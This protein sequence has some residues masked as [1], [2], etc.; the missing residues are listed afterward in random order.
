MIETLYF[1]SLILVL[2]L[3]KPHPTS[4]IF[5][6][7]VNLFHSITATVSLFIDLNSA[8]ID[9]YFIFELLACFNMSIFVFHFISLIGN[10]KCI[11]FL[12]F[13]NTKYKKVVL[14]LG[15]PCAIIVIFQNISQG[16]D[17]IQHGYI[18]AYKDASSQS[19]KA[20]SLFPLV[21][22][23]YFYSFISY[24]TTKKF[25]YLQIMICITFS[26]FL[27]GSRSFFLYSTVTI[28]VFL[29]VMRTY[30]YKK[31]GVML[32]LMLPFIILAGIF[33]ETSQGNQ[34]I[35]YRLALEFINIPMIISNIDILNN[36]K[37]SLMNVFLSLLPHSIIIPLG[38]QPSNSLAT[39]FVKEFDPGWA[40]A[41]GGFGFSIIAE[42]VYR[43]GYLGLVTIP[44]MIVILLH[45]LERIFLKGDLLDKAL[46]MSFFYGLLMWVRSDFIEIYRLLFII[47][48]CFYAKRLVYRNAK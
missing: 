3:L 24:F 26:Y 47:I 33:R 12:S 41:G 31:V 19:I 18:A 25:I 11:N 10:K 20:T 37:Q 34:G 32:S 14:W 46:S 8:V 13:S 38:I 17:A 45:K 42:I 9:K 23:F 2:L 5:I 30:S 4:F 6:F 1:I 22:I 15:V 35:V 43:F 21:L 44:Y 7:V 16:I 36:T 29:I 39:E 28:L 40:E 48:F 27:Y